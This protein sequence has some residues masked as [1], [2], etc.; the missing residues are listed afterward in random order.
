MST[1]IDKTVVAP[2]PRFAANLESEHDAF[3]G[4]IVKDEFTI[5][6]PPNT[7]VLRAHVDDIDELVEMVG[8]IKKLIVEKLELEAK[9]E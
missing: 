7:A 2:K 3:K 6:G 5:Q 4:S 9:Y 1:K 8:D